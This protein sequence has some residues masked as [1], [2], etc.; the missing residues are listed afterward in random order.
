M[1]A[2]ESVLNKMDL[3]SFIGPSL[4]FGGAIIAI[5]GN[6]WDNRLTGW[7]RITV[8]GW[9]AAMVALA[10]LAISLASAWQTA[11]ETKAR[12]AAA[13]AEI[14]IAWKGLVA[15]FGLM[16]WEIDGQ[17][18][19][20]DAALIERMLED[21][22]LQL[23]DQI[24]L[25]GEA[26]HHHGLWTENICRSATTGYQELRRAQTIYVGIIDADLITKMKDVATDY[27]I[28][29]MMILPPCGEMVLSM[30]HP[31]RLQSITNFRELPRYLE[32]LLALRNE[33]DK[34]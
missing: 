2:Q 26:P 4:A 8:T 34:G 30:D 31:V 16:L 18:S 10:A 29:V 9:A 28:Q 21:Q 15:P 5:I 22:T 24:D 19:N 11:Q 27:M 25:R 23:V 13:I 6:T 1:G 32:S 12:R 33:L 7:R 3:L 20:P 17:Q 14:E